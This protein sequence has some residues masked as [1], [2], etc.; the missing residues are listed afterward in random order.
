MAVKGWARRIDSGQCQF[1]G[2]PLVARAAPKRDV[3]SVDNGPLPTSH[4]QIPR[5]FVETQ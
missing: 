1:T 5:T 3:T 4:I 2:A